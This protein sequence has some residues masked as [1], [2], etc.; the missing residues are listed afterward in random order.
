[1][2]GAD[3]QSSAPLFLTDSSSVGCNVA[4]TGRFILVEKQTVFDEIVEA[5]NNTNIIFGEEIK[6]VYGIFLFIQMCRMDPILYNLCDL[7]V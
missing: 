7:C 1:M 4:A 5:Y 2:K 6:P 3:D